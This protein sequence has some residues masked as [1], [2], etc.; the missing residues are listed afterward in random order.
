LE[1]TV[2]IKRIVRW[3]LA[4]SRK[5]IVED[6]DLYQ[7]IVELEERIRYLEDENIE[8]SNCFYELTNSLDAIDARIDILVEH[9]EVDRNV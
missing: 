1:R 5:P 2:V 7:K 6:I 9:I 3:F 8:N 4:P